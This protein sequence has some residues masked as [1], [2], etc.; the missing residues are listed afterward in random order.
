MIGTSRRTFRASGLTVLIAML[1]A[2][3]S[4][5]S[6]AQTPPKLDAETAFARISP[7]ATDDNEVRRD[8]I[9]AQMRDA[10]L[11][12]S[13]TT[14]DGGRGTDSEVGYNI[15]TQ[16]GPS[17]AKVI[18]LV[19]HYDTFQI[20]RGEPSHGVVDNAASVVAMI[21]TAAR[22][23]HMPLKHQ[24]QVLFTDQEE[25]GLIGARAWIAENGVSHIAGVINADVTG[26]G[27]TL[28]YGLNNGEQSKPLVAALESICAMEDRKCLS[29][30]NYPSSDDRAFTAAGAPAVSIGYLPA[31]DAQ[32]MH[33]FLNPPQGE[34]SSRGD[35]PH[36]LSLIHT[37]ADRMD[38]INPETM[39]LAASVYEA[40][41]LLLDETLD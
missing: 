3:Q 31:E 5:T 28:M 14:F 10:G 35:L 30:P 15:S 36:L 21:A 39:V 23:S 1:A 7:L 9:V 16:F 17:D 33:R 38:Q 25:L 6:G 27:S 11:T 2:C 22:L 12:P 40:L 41:V 26:Y 24:I 19:A 4:F 29:F 18:L 34:R 32:T 37:P 20:S 8:L 13:I